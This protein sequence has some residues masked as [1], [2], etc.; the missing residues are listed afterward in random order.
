MHTIIPRDGKKSKRRA[1][2]CAKRVGANGHTMKTVYN[3]V[4]QM[5]GERWLDANGIE[6]ARYKYACDSDGIIVRSLDM[7]AEKEY[8]YEYEGG[9]IVRATKADIELSCEIVTSKV[10]VNTVKYY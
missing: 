5:V 10:I 7:T 2:K 3:S 9:R 8:N 1:K 4:G 6:T